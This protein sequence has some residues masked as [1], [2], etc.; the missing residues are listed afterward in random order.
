MKPSVAFYI[1]IGFIAGAII[2]CLFSVF[3]N[4]LIGAEANYFILRNY[5]VP[6]GLGAIVGMSISFL[7]Y[8]SNRVLREKAIVEE[9]AI[10][11][12]LT[13]LYNRRGF[14]F[15]VNPQI[16]LAIRNN[17][18]LLLVYIDIDNLKGINDKLGHDSGD[19]AL[20][21][22]ANLLK[23]TFRKSDIIARLG[24]DEFVIFC[25]DTE[26][27]SY[28]IITDHIKTSLEDFNKKANIFTLSLSFG[29]AVYDPKH[30][31]SIDKLLSQADAQMYK[32]KKSKNNSGRT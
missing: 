12:D 5:F 24:G 17:K 23:N 2:A 21:E 19:R 22:T 6:A 4:I 15:L 20:I 1:I 25:I 10:T 11:D 16:E 18:K 28:D 31:L 9:K 30:P 32:E 14:F 8:R 3:Q 13:G 26:E 7:W 27:A 29:K